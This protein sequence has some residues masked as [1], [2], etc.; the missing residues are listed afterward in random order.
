MYAPLPIPLPRGEGGR[1]VRFAQRFQVLER[2][3]GGALL[4]A[5]DEQTV[6]DL[7]QCLPGHGVLQVDRHLSVAI[8]GRVGPGLLASQ[9]TGDFALPSSTVRPQVILKQAR[10]L[11]SRML[12]RMGKRAMRKLAREEEA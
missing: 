11:W 4:L 8:L 12:A 9:G 5:L 6:G 1:L 2:L 3:V 7:A 10:I